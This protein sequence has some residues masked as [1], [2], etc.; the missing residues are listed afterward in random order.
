[1]GKLKPWQAILFIAAVSALGFAVWWSLR[2]EVKMSDT[3]HMADV[4]TGEDFY[5]PTRHAT[6]PGM[7]PK[8]QE[9]TLL[10]V[11]EVDHG[12]VIPDRYVRAINDIPGVHAAV[13][14]ATHRIKAAR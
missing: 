7:N 13:D 10:P 1:M 11:A 14:P 12:L 3:L 8:T 4:N 9:M 2:S 6:I 5:L